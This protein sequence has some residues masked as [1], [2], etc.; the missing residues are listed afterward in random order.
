MIVRILSDNLVWAAPLITEHFIISC[1][2][3]IYNTVIS[4][5]E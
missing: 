2:V 3:S 5:T 1:T 4:I